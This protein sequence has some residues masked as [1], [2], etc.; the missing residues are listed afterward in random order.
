MLLKQVLEWATDHTHTIHVSPPIAPIQVEMRDGN[1]ETSELY[2]AVE[3][4]FDGTYIRLPL[5]KECVYPGTFVLFSNGDELHGSSVRQIVT[6]LSADELKINIFCPPCPEDCV[7]MINHSFF[8]VTTE[9]CLI[10]D[11]LFGSVVSVSHKKF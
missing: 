9:V 5:L 10:L 1:G 4:V 3:H 2:N 7:T 8:E 11:Y 6:T